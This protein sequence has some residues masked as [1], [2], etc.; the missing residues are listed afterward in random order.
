L[1]FGFVLDQ[2]KRGDQLEIESATTLSD[3]CGTLDLT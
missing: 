1:N 3:K 2:W